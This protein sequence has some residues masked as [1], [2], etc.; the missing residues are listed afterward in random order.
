MSRWEEAAGIWN[1]A[2]GEGRY[3]IEAGTQEHRTDVVVKAP[4]FQTEEAEPAR[5][6]GRRLASCP[7]YAPCHRS[8][9]TVSFIER[10]VVS[11][12]TGVLATQTAEATAIRMVK[13]ILA[14]ALSD[15]M[16]DWVRVLDLVL[17]LELSV[18]GLMR[19]ELQIQRF[20]GLSTVR[21]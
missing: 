5:T 18:V 3:Q 6:L 9:A 21:H 4:E 10:K 8:S 14:E 19:K 1:E 12:L 20:F 13:R 7:A 17:E 15:A 16:Q 11:Q 2:V